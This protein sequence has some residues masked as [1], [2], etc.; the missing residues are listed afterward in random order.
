MPRQPA[1]SGFLLPRSR[2]AAV[3]ATVPIT[4]GTGVGKD[5][6][7]RVLP[8]QVPP[9]RDRPA[10]ILPLARAAAILGISRKAPWEQRK[11]YGVQ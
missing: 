2:D 3:D 11:R 4:G 9:L 7:A 8:P 5:S 10:N 6:L 1:S